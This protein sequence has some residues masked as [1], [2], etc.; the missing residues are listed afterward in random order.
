[1]GTLSLWTY[2]L[3]K[4]LLALMLFIMTAVIIV[5]VI[6]RTFLG[7]SIFWSEELARYLFVWVSFIG[8]SIALRKGDL[9]AMDFLEGKIKGKWQ[10]VYQC[11]IQLIVLTFVVIAFYFGLK[12]IFTPTVLNNISPALRLPMSLVYAAVPVGF[13]LMII[14]ILDILTHI[15]IKRKGIEREVA[16]QWE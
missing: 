2:Q 11:L 10:L 16:E 8:A 14:H 5:Q 15:V 3:S 13:G 1:M 9:V 12:Q 6:C 7:F 4:K